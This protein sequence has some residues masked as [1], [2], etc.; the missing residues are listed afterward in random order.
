MWKQSCCYGASLGKTYDRKRAY[1]LFDLAETNMQPKKFLVNMLTTFRGDA[2][3]RDGRW[4]E[5]EKLYYAAWKE[6]PT[7][8]HFLYKTVHNTGMSIRD[9]FSR[10]KNCKRRFSVDTLT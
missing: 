10:R 1:E 7:Q 4:P 5:A 6:D 8:L 2:L 3:E 9:S